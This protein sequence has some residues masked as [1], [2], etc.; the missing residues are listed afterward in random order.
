MC[1]GDFVEVYCE[2][3]DFGCVECIDDGSCV[4]G[5]EYYECIVVGGFE[6][7]EFWGDLVGV[8]FGLDVFDSDVFGVDL[9]GCVDGVVFVIVIESE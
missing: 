1:G 2:V 8:C 3:F 9:D 6:F 4:F 7:F 5:V